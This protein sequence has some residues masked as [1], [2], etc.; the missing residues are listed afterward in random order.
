MSKLPLY[1]DDKLMLLDVGA[2]GG[3]VPHW[4]RYKSQ[5]KAILCEPDERSY[6]GLRKHIAEDWIILPVALWDRSGTVELKLSRKP[7]ASSIYTPN[8]EFLRR[9]PDPERFEVVGISEI[10]VDTIKNQAAKNSISQIDFIKIDAH[11][12]EL[13]I[14]K[15]A[16]PVM[17]TVIGIEVEVALTEL[18]VGQPKFSELSDYMQDLHFEL[19]DLR[20]YYWKRNNEEGLATRSRGQLIF[21]DALFF[22][23]PEYFITQQELTA[24]SA[25]HVLSV[26]LIYGYTDL[27]QAALDYR[28]F[29]GLFSSDQ[30]GLLRRSIREFSD[31]GVPDF[32][33]KSRLSLVASNVLSMHGFSSQNDAKLGNVR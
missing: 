9:F 7:E 14:V 17:D 30:L 5:L 18:W 25:L 20:R 8:M 33:G 4:A 27:A 23:S 6:I 2:A 21:G 1:N 28:E 12:A 16:G 15:E 19:M 13:G 31:R 11:G 22:R 32:R 26:Y 3:L 10:P 29:S 24:T